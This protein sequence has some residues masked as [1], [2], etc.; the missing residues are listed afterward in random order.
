[1]TLQRRARHGTAKQ[2]QEVSYANA[3]PPLLG[4]QLGRTGAAMMAATMTT[5]AVM[6]I[7]AIVAM[8]VPSVLDVDQ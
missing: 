6:M 3:D 5:A 4:N 8:I 7:F 2:I 1:M